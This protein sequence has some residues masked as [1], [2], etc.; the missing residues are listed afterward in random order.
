MNPA[1]V[2]YALLAY[3]AWGI[4]PVYWKWLTHLSPA[5]LLSHRILW[6][7]L[8]CAAMLTGLRRWDEI[9][10]CFTRPREPW[11]VCGAALLLG[12]NWLIFLYAVATNRI[13]ETSLGYYLNPLINVVLAVAFLGESLRR[14]QAIAVVLAS[15]GVLGLVID[16]SGLPW[17][18]L[19]LAGTFAGYGLAHK[20][21]LVRPIPRLWIEVT[22]MSP[23]AAGFLAFFVEPLGGALVSEPS[24][25]RWLLII[26]GP[27]TALPLLWFAS[28]AR[29]L[30]F[31]TLGLFQ[32]IAPTLSLGIAVFAYDEAFTPAHGFAF[33]FIW[34]A[35]AVYSW[36]TR[37]AGTVG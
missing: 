21:T 19:A 12:T 27:V 33:V 6:T 37:R 34:S 13:L 31:S 24:A 20:V 4:T 28:A 2:V 3:G 29:R 22:V 18:S 30:P 1:G 23:L 32:Y 8:F 7:V 11:I 26:A 15:V 36:D 5:E 9:R 16:H 10:A 35:L 14:M 17:I 25:T